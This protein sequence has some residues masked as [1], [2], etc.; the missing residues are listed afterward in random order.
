MAA[1]RIVFKI[2]N[3]TSYIVGVLTHL[4]P[5]LFEKNR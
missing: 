2:F 4:K 1:Q 3:G 5:N